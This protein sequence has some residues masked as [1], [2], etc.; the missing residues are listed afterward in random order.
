[1]LPNHLAGPIFHLLPAAHSD[2][3]TSSQQVW[4]NQVRAGFDCPMQMSN[5]AILWPAEEKRAKR[6][7]LNLANYGR[8]SMSP[9]AGFACRSLVVAP[10][11]PARVMRANYLGVRSSG[12]RLWTSRKHDE[13]AIKQ[14]PFRRRRERPQAASRS[15]QRRNSLV[16]QD[17]A[18][19]AKR[20]T[21]GRRAADLW[22]RGRASERLSCHCLAYLRPLCGAPE[23]PQSMERGGERE[24]TS[25]WEGSQ[26]PQNIRR[27]SQSVI[28]EAGTGTGTGRAAW[29]G[30]SSRTRPPV[31]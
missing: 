1:M 25:L 26:I 27:L 14:S 9:S 17:L 23:I 16:A 15:P 10:M 13:G 12:G 4:R 2:A 24:E 18:P 5:C 8:Y 11:A 7:H 20:R 21:N 6:S 28:V 29:A 3:L 19:R 31:I 22:R 30:A